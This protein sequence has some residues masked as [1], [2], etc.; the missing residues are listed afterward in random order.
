MN[1]AWAQWTQIKDPEFVWELIV[2]LPDGWESRRSLY[3]ERCMPAAFLAG[4]YEQYQYEEIGWYL[5]HLRE[6]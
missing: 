2:K 5:T 3:T 1:Y 4:S 6:L